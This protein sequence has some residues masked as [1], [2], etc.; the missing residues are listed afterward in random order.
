[1]RPPLGDATNVPA[2]P[3]KVSSAAA[4]AKPATPKPAAKASPPKRIVRRIIESDS[5]ESDDGSDGGGDGGGDAEASDAE[6]AEGAGGVDELTRAVSAVKIATAPAPVATAA[7][8][9]A[10]AAA[11]PPPRLVLDIGQCASLHTELV[12]AGT[13]EDA[14]AL[15]VLTR[16]RG[17][18]AKGRMQAVAASG[19]GKAVKKL[20]RHEGTKVAQAAA[21]LCDHWRALAGIVP[22]AMAVYYTDAEGARPLT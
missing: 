6:G 3:L 10:A 1:M 2:S 16:L 5:D 9:P 8:P 20:T 4:A 7:P 13:R 21:A 17:A 12:K 19:L 15:A 11:A 18:D 14:A 22:K